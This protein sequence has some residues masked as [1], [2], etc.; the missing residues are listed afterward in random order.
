MTEKKEPKHCDLKNY[1]NLK[2][3]DEYY[4]D[5]KNLKKLN[6]FYKKPAIDAQKCQIDFD[7]FDKKYHLNKYS[8][9]NP[10]NATGLPKPIDSNGNIINNIGVTK[11]YDFSKISS[12]DLKYYLSLVNYYHEKVYGG[13]IFIKGVNGPIE[14]ALDLLKQCQY[15]TRLALAKILYPVMDR[16][17]G[18]EEFQNESIIPQRRDSSSII[19][20]ELE[21][22][23]NLKNEKINPKNNNELVIQQKKSIKNSPLIYLT[24]ALNDLI[25][26]DNTQKTNW[27]NY[28]IAQV[29]NKIDY[30][31]LKVLIEIAIKMRLE[32]PEDINKEI[33]NSETLSK[34]I[35]NELDSKESDLDGL[36]SL[37]NISQ[38]QKV[39]TDE[40][41]NLKKIIKQGEA[42]ETNVKNIFYKIV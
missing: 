2:K 11:K 4:K 37:Y 36:R 35:K 17:G 5:D 34:K 16:M 28:I 32:L 31:N 24:F 39:Q 1:P 29:N 20:K 9:P 40:F 8:E 19:N 14:K 38:T 25:G 41:Q 26:A 12:E 7:S 33:K 18:L 13:N 23:M 30:K 27:L 3:F 42:W 6:I 22:N 15:N 21:K 10:D